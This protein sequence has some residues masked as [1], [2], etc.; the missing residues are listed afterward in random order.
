MLGELPS[1]SRCRHR[2]VTAMAHFSQV[3]VVGKEDPAAGG[4]LDSRDRI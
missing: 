4:H 3:D 1:T 2:V